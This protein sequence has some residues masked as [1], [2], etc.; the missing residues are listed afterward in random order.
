MYSAENTITDKNSK[1][2]SWKD[3]L[4]LTD[5]T[6]SSVIA[7]RLSVISAN[8]NALSLRAAFFCSEERS[9]SDPIYC[10]GVKFKSSLLI[11]RDY[12]CR[13]VGHEVSCHSRGSKVSGK[14]TGSALSLKRSGWGAT[15]DTS[16]LLLHLA[17]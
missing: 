9:K 3:H 6:D 17:K 7:A 13:A 1:I 11:Q 10:R 16:S 4:A 14:E 8:K 2:R 12:S 5:S 15:L